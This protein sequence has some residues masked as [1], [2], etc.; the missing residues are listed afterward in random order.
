MRNVR[1]RGALVSMAAVRRAKK[2]DW[3]VEL[4]DIA[5]RQLRL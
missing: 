1:V 4:P 5:R 2:G 3:T